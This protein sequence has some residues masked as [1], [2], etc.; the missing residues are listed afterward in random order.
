MKK[1]RRLSLV[2]LGIVAL[3]TIAG[4]TA[5]TA[6]TSP[7]PSASASGTPSPT[8]TPRPELTTITLNADSIVA[9]DQDG[10]TLATLDYYDRG[11]D[12][13]TALTGLFGFAPAV[14]VIDPIASDVKFS[15]TIY[16]WEGFELR[17]WYGYENDPASGVGVYP[18]APPALITVT[19]ASVRGVAI[20]APDGA[21]V[22]EGQGDLSA[23]YPGE[24]TSYTDSDGQLIEI[25]TVHCVAVTLPDQGNGGNP[26]NCVDVWAAPADGPITSLQAPARR[27][28]GM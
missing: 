16:N 12:T 23:R 25:A 18:Y 2:A 9:A 19:V 6:G 11:V 21:R 5:P 4:C 3:A 13:A 15:G 28:Y 10:Q 26:R 17:W 22:G 8:P 24:T 1:P 7:T 20:Q 27:D 14:E